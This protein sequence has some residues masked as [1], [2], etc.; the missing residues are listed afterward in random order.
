MSIVNCDIYKYEMNNIDN[1]CNESKEE[2]Q[3]LNC[4]K[5]AVKDDSDKDFD[6]NMDG[7]AEEP[8]N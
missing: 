6:I 8:V 1:E 2:E 4:N 7:G 3:V 5:N